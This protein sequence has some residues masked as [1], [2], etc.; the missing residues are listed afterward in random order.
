[1]SHRLGTI[2]DADL[3]LVLDGGTVAQAGRHDEL[4]E[5]GG[6]YAELFSLQAAGYRD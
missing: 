3:I 1:M 2:R 6:L 5:A 4:V